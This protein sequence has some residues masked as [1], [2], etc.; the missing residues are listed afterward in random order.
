MLDKGIKQFR[1][2]ENYYINKFTKGQALSNISGCGK[3][4]IGYIS[5]H[6][7]ALKGHLNN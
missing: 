3:A 6:G 5:T 7:Q 1:Y 4:P 2:I